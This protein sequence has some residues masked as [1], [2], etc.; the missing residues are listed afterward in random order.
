[1]ALPTERKFGRKS[2]EERHMHSASYD[3]F[4]FYSGLLITKKKKK[5]LRRRNKNGPG[6]SKHTHK[7][8]TERD[9]FRILTSI[10]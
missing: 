4:M 9:P 5:D 3:L 7:T 6:N 2:E 1:M 8:R 10:M